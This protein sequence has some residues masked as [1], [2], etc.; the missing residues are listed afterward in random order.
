M[1][2]GTI[3]DG[4]RIHLGSIW[5]AWMHTSGASGNKRRQNDMAKVHDNLVVRGISGSLGDQVVFK[6]YFDGRTILSKKPT[7]PDDREFSEKQKGHQGAF[8]EAAAYAK[9]AA[10][11]EA[12]YAEMARGTSRTAYNIALA[13][14]FRPP[15]IGAI[16]L[17]GWTGR[18]GESI[19]IKAVDDV[20]VVR[21]MVVISDEED[22]VIEQG[23]AERVDGVW[24]V[25]TTTQAAPRAARVLAAA[26]DLPGHIGQGMEELNRGGAE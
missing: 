14:W 1:D 22:V 3:W 23:E 10:K 20:M 24:W 7:F 21:V 16:D 2:L 8:K 9:Q 4:F 12:I 5:D 15:E 17:E 18:V 6:H 25:Y 11:T 19:R 13:D 26:E